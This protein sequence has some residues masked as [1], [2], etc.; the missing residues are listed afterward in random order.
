MEE[1]AILYICTGN[2]KKLFQQFYDS[3]EQNFLP[4]HTHH[5]YV[6]TD[7]PELGEYDESKVSIIPKEYKKWPAATLMR[8][9]DF[10]SIREILLSH[11]YV[12]FCNADL[13][14]YAP[15]GDEI[16]P[17]AEHPLVGVQHIQYDKPQLLLHQ[18]A[19][20]TEKNLF[21]NAYIDPCEFPYTYIFG[22]FNGGLPGPYLEMAETI[23]RW[24]DEDLRHGIIPVWHDESFLNAYRLEHPDIFKVLPVQ[25]AY[26]D[27]CGVKDYDDIKII[28]LDKESFFETKN[29]RDYMGNLGEQFARDRLAGILKAL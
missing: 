15:V 5:Y 29:F 2:Y 27:L 9:H 11:R 21:S 14:I 8:Y 17:S 23:A 20:N 18:L 12:Y 28:K 26:P 4:G 24:T 16:L 22:C 6:W 13:N 19:E 7:S 25:Y 1:V 10:L 3:V